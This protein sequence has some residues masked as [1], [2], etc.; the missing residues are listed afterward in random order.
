M[1]RA[2]LIFLCLF[3]AGANLSFATITRTKTMGNVHNFVYDDA[4]IFSWP[5]TAVGFS[6]RFLLELGEDAFS[7]ASYDPPVGPSF[8]NGYGGGA[9]FGLNDVH[10]L[11][12]FVTGND[13]VNGGGDSDFF[14]PLNLDDAISLLYG[15]GAEN[16]DVGIGF[17]LARSRNEQT[18]PE[19][20]QSKQSVGRMGILGGI[21]YWMENDNSM[22][23]AIEFSNTSITD[24]MYDTVEGAV[25]TIAEDD[26]FSSF[27]A[28][29]RYFH[30][31]TDD[32]QLV[33]YFAFEMDNRGVMQ[34]SDA[35]DE[36]ESDKT[37]TTT[38]DLALGINHFPTDAIQLVVV[39]GMMFMSTDVTVQG[40]ATEENSSRHIPYVKGGI[41]AEICNW[42]DM[43]AGVEK[44]MYS[45]EMKG[46]T[47]GAP[48]MEY[49]GAEFQGY[50]GGGIHIGD[51]TIDTQ[52][53]PNI[54]FSGPNFISGDQ[55]H[56]NTRVS[57]V[58]PW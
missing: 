26:G 58:R 54:F 46:V 38:I 14:F 42:L 17:N 35:D 47:D 49:S 33:P 31:H 22:D 28:R 1:K 15:Y 32:I 2:I 41:D 18:A 4:N 11:G 21:T 10:H 8:P 36:M 51:W 13:R 39:G 3:M 44:Q 27:A 57:I 37:E 30:N 40:E 23:I 52:V 43:R 45:D 29:F 25:E 6:D 55:L 16:I 53:D 50:I 24:E 20:Q 48:V 56:L 19:D 34:D 7:N 12:F 5:S 9:L